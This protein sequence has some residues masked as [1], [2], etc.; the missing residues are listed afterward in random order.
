M[1]PIYVVLIINLVIWLGLFGYLVKMNGQINDMKNK[2][3]KLDK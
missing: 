3:D 2:M 1:E